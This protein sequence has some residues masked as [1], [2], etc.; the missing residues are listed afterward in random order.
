[1][2]S[3]RVCALGRRRACEQTLACMRSGR[4]TRPK[5]LRQCTH[6]P[7]ER[8]TPLQEAQP[9]RRRPRHRAHL[10]RHKRGRRHAPLEAQ[11]RRLRGRKRGIA[12]CQPARAWRQLTEAQRARG[13]VRRR[14][15]V[16]S[17]V[18]ARR[19][20]RRRRSV[21]V[22][23]R[24]SVRCGRCGA[25]RSGATHAAPPASSAGSGAQLWS[26]RVHRRALPSEPLA[27]RETT[28]KDDEGRTGRNDLAGRETMLA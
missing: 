15:C 9:E 20:R 25:R 7:P 22:R 5:E 4:R 28:M 8:S 21:H 11:R 27:I 2:V 24:H 16:G 12:A 17:C 10:R 13:A 26:Q 6:Q 1:M 23:K 19:A 3:A 18:A 14:A